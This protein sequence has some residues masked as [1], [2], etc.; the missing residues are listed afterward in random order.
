MPVKRLSILTLLLALAMIAYMTI[1]SRGNWDFV[2]AFRGAKLLAIIAVGVAVSTSTLLFQTI[3]QNRI[4]TPSIMGFDALYVLIITMMVFFVG[5]QGML[6]LGPY[7]LF[8]LNTVLLLLASFLLFGT[9]IFEHGR[10]LTRMILTGV[11]LGTLF[12]S[13]TSFAT[14]MIDPNEYAHIQIAS[15]ASFNSFDMELLYIGVAIIIACLAFVWTIRHRLDVISLGYDVAINLGE[16]VRA[17]Q[18][19]AL[20]V[21]AI[22]VSVST[23][24]VGPVAFLGLLVVSIAHLVTPSPYHSTLLLSSGLISCLIL[25][26]GQTLMERV[27]QMSTPLAVIIDFVGGLVF[28]LLLL[29]RLKK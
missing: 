29:Q 10:D 11:I 20:G 27:L 22:L 18:L 23:A 14:R 1:G 9:L 13:L 8:T 12:R 16:N 25:V 5:G 17:V 28:L 26:G 4:L 21:I 2:L 6:S 15:Y 7:G 3:A 24:I 19:L